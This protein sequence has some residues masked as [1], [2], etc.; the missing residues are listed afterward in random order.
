MR[1]GR[2]ILLSDVHNWAWAKKS[3]QI[4]Q[5]LSDEFDFDIVHL[6]TQPKTVRY[7]DYDLALTYGWSYVNNILKVAENRRISGV[8][9]HKDEKIMT[10]TIYP[11][12][13]RCKWVHANSIMLKNQLDANG[14]KNVFYVP[15]GVNENLFKETVPIPESR[16]R[17]VVGHVGKKCG[18]GTNAK[19]HKTVIEP[20]CAQ[21][22]VKYCGHYNNYRN[23]IPHEQMPQ[24]YQNIDVFIVASTTDGTP[25][26][27]LEAAACG[28]P[29]IS[30][31]IGNMP[32]FIKD[33]YNGFLINGLDIGKYVE[34]IKI[35]ES[36][37]KLLIEMGKNA[38]KTVE[39]GWTWK[40]Q[41]E[42]YRK[43]FQNIIAT[44]GLR[45]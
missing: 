42:N 21:A 8:T 14:F 32:E 19:G 37:R 39:S 41:A 12:L 28:R 43:M 33:C 22:G 25:N 40:I 45:N 2:I 29:I 7:D 15:N 35:L 13:R 30:N 27:A 1:K 44:V 4:K 38:R 10:N 9:A 6:L 36:D 16:D 18:H 34:K 20:A 17:L 5:Y 11:S 23:A 31:H 3:E 24:F 26:G